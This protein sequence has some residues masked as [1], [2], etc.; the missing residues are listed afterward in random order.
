M[1]TTETTL[2]ELDLP[3]SLNEARQKLLKIP[4]V[5]NYVP[6]TD[7]SIEEID[8]GIESMINELS[9]HL[10]AENMVEFI[11]YNLALTEEEK[12]EFFSVPERSPYKSK[13]S[14]STDFMRIQRKLRRTYDYLMNTL[15]IIFSDNQ[16]IN[17]PIEYM[18]LLEEIKGQ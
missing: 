4:G 9:M 11:T 2:Q 7:A 5:D 18:V 8:E 14:L 6:D 17:F 12:A 13:I 15:C 1:N 3:Q 10:D 16:I